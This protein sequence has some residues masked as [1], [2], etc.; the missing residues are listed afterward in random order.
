MRKLK[1]VKLGLDPWVGLYYG[2]GFPCVDT[3]QKAVFSSLEKIFQP[4]GI[5]WVFIFE[6]RKYG[7]NCE[8]P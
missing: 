7:V 2:S 6:A 1:V 8:P 4:E 5:F 3:V